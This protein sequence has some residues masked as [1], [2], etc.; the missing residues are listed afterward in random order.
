MLTIRIDDDTNSLVKIIKSN[1]PGYV[2]GPVLYD[3]FEGTYA[4]VKIEKKNPARIL[5]FEEANPQIIFNL[6]D[7]KA[8]EY[9]DKVLP[10]EFQDFQERSTIIFNSALF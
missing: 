5:T 3:S 7:K 9:F 4:L 10:K 6:K 8:Q 1:P 2:F